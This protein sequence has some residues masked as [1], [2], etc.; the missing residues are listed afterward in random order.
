MK[1]LLI[2]EMRLASSPLSYI[3]LVAAGMTLLPGYPI[4]V[5]AF[6]ICFGIFHSFQNAREA[7]DT[8]YTVLLPVK[9]SDFVGAKYVFTCMIQTLGF[10]LCAALT[11]VRMT[12]LSSS[13][14][15][16]NNA[17][18][19][20]SPVSL[21]FTLLIFAAF[22]VLFVGGY[23]KTAYKIGMPFLF[24]GIAALLLI[25][26]AETLHH[27]PGLGFLN[28][29]TGERLGLQLGVLA[30]AALVYAAVTALA[31]RTAKKRFERIDL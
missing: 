2:K 7:N 25:A 19:N 5:G 1:S 3:F 13:A 6:F 15:Y 27:L 4:L 28:T 26:A 24:F 20:P 22:N 11:A 16:V 18:M 30:A 8:L 10:T 17:M 14:P 31:C 12:A 21:A 23:F 29:T 9:K